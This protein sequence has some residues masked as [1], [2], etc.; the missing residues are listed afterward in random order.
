MKKN[1]PSKESTEDYKV[2]IEKTLNNMGK[3]LIEIG[4]KNLKR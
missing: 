1:K 2:I 3:S 4:K